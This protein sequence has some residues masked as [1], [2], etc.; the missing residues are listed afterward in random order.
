VNAWY[1]SR[2]GAP[3]SRAIIRDPDGL[4][5]TYWEDRGFALTPVAT[6]GRWQDLNDD[7]SPVQLAEALLVDLGVPMGLVI[8]SVHDKRAELRGR[9]QA[10][11]PRP[12]RVPSRRTRGN[13]G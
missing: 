12:R 11:A 4:L 5:S 7:V 8:A 6:A 13:A 3:G 10:G 1:Y 2:W 9:I